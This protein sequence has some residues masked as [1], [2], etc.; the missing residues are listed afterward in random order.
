MANWTFDRMG[1]KRAGICL[2]CEKM[3]G[4]RADQLEE[5]ALYSRRGPDGAEYRVAHGTCVGVRMKHGIGGRSRLIG[6]PEQ[7]I[8]TTPPPPPPPAPQ[9]AAKVPRELALT[10]IRKLMAEHKISKDEV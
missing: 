4:S 2:V 8:D 3:T 5:T 9:D 6:T 10:L 7:E 1:A